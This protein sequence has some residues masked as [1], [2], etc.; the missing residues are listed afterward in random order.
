MKID[1]NK[2]PLSWSAL[3]SFEYSPEQW[4]SRYILKEKQDESKEMMFGKSIGKLLETDP[5]FLPQIQRHSK[6]EHPFNVVFS[7]IKLVGYADSFCDKTFRKL[8]EYKT[9]KKKWDQKRVDTH[10]QID[11]YLLM[12]YITNK[13][14]PFEVEVTLVW[15]PTQETGDFSISFI[16]PIKENIKAFNT[17]RTMSDILHFGQFINDSVTEMQKYVDNR[18]CITSLQ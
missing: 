1:F 16:E 12:N 17:K 8:S 4:Y 13:I 14:D 11:M 18:P 5:T 6:M 9:G 3:S 10:G 7:G 15:M 2:R